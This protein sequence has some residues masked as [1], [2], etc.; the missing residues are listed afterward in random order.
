VNPV[1]ESKELKILARI[2]RRLLDLKMNSQMIAKED[3]NVPEPSDLHETEQ[4]ENFKQTENY[5]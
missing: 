4:P 2:H 3:D 5:C 1:K